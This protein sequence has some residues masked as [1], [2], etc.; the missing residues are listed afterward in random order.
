MA[1]KLEIE[2]DT[3][4]EALCVPRTALAWRRDGWY[5][6][7]VRDGMPIETAV[8][9]GPCANGDLVVTSGLEA[10]DRLMMGMGT[11][12]G[13]AAVGAIATTAGGGAQ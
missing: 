12:R 8:E 9:V 5:V 13:R 3:V 2:T 10:G 11:A 1:V 7:R 6:L 4:Q